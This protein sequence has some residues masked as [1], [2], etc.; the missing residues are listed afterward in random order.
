MRITF[1]GLEN[2]SS[3]MICFSDI[4][5]LVEV[6]DDDSGRYASFEFN[7]RSGL[8]AVQDGQYHITI[9][10]DTISNVVNVQDAVGQA[11][12]I[13]PT[14]PSSTAMSVALALRACP[15]IAAN[16]DVSCTN[17]TVIVIAKASGP[18]F[19]QYAIVSGTNIDSSYLTFFSIDGSSTS[20]LHNARVLVDIYKYQGQEYITTLEKTFINGSA[21]FDISSVLSTICEYG[22]L[23]PFSFTVGY[24]MENGQ[25]VSA[26]FKSGNFAV[27]GYKTKGSNRYELLNTDYL[28]AM[29]V[30]RGISRNYTNNTLLYTYYPRI[31]MTVYSNTAS[32]VNV[33]VDYYNS[34]MARLGGF[35]S[36]FTVTDNVANVDVILNSGNNAQYWTHAFYVKLSFGSEEYMFNVIRPIK[37]AETALRMYWYNELG[38]KQF[39]DFTASYT[40]SSTI[41]SETYTDF[42]DISH[43]YENDI[44]ET[45]SY[46]SHLIDRSGIFIFDS[47]Q[48]SKNVWTTID[49]EEYNVLI[50]SV[51]LEEV[52]E[53]VFQAIV[54]YKLS[55]SENR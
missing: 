40:L 26:L 1:N 7:F 38:G 14:D 30:S 54:T 13:S 32:T 42:Y 11:F 36:A 35:T 53:N 39:F 50:R 21:I 2:W 24:L 20:P 5:N 19:N 27:Y 22:E 25:F 4:P 48:R 8:V 43:V 46:R 45:Y 29:A 6:A 15:N 44:D 37:A 12:W 55:K 52:Q 33:T 31:E 41:N 23:T 18:I 47:L 16:F 51:A 9:L 10:D 3:P 34:A 49:N 17:A 28:G